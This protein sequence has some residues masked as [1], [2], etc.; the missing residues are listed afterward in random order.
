MSLPSP[1]SANLRSA[2][3]IAQKTVA[4]DAR[5]GYAGMG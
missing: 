1:L 2:P 5:R 4:D 3:L